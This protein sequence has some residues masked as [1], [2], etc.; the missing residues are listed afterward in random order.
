MKKY[1]SIVLFAVLGCVLS[2]CEDF[3]DLKPVSTASSVNFY[4]T[5][6]DINNAV[7]A[8]YAKLQSGDLYAGD[9]ITLLETRS[10]NVEDQNPGGNAGRDYN[11]DKFTAGADN[12]VF[13]DVWKASYN[14]IMRCNVV[15]ENSHVMTNGEL[16]VQYEAEAR[17]I[18]ALMYFNLVRMFGDVPLQLHTI[19][20]EEAKKC[21]RN[22]T[23]D[24]YK[25][26]EEDLLF[27]KANLPAIYE[28]DSQK[29]RATSGAAAALL[30]K[31]YLTQQRWADCADILG[32]FITSEYKNV[33]SLVNPIAKVFSID[34]KL[35]PEMVFVVRY[36]K[37]I[38]DEGRSFPTYYKSAQLLDKNLRKL[39]STVP[40]AD[41][42]LALLE[43]QKV[44]SDNS[45]FVKFYD[46]LDPLTKK[47]GFDQPIIRY[48]DVLLMYVEALNEIEYNPSA[49]G[50]AFYYLNLVR[51][52]AKAPTYSPAT[53]KN[54]EEFRD[55]VLLERRLELPLE[56][57]RWFDLIRTGTAEEAMAKVGI[58]I[59]RNDYL[60]PIPKSE[61]E[62]INNPA[63]IRTPA[64]KT[65][66]NRLVMLSVGTAE[67]MT[68]IQTI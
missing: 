28:N 9:L 42:R 62:V 21:V 51:T 35:N 56:L 60:Y 67:S 46:T 59:T 40:T 7:I 61:I 37:T 55:A 16:K 17:F 20:T 11:I 23:E 32:K 45:P 14:A 36:E 27:A 22:K 64:T 3:L 8:C 6:S 26:I 58:N 39:Y 68:R 12:I 65:N 15:L 53:L 5:D 33:Y 50:D 48:A 43:S 57:H 25:A 19:S 34:N 1:I 52:R 24:V 38:V 4:K 47:A 2:S 13:Q 66:K 54:Q 18:R 49:R 31:V 44:D 10:D 29:S 41:Q 30:G 63:S